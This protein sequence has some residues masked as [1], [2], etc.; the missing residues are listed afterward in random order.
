MQSLLAPLSDDEDE[1]DAALRSA[2]LLLLRMQ[3]GQAATHLLMMTRELELLRFIP[4][5]DSRGISEVRPDNDDTWKLD[6]NSSQQGPAGLLDVNGRVSLSNC[7]KCRTRLLS[8][9]QVIRPFTILPAN[10]SERARLQKEL[11]QAGHR[12]PTMGIDEYLELEKERGNIITGGGYVS[13]SA[14]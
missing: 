2:T 14:L 8:F 12:L 10:V 4:D 6:V 13:V 5:E 11:F 3:W 7:S 9:L 1:N